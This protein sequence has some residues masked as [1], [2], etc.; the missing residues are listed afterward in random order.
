ML[1]FVPRTAAASNTTIVSFPFQPLFFS[2]FP[3][4]SFQH[5]LVSLPSNPVGFRLNPR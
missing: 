3:F 2:F 1:A 4:P 5:G